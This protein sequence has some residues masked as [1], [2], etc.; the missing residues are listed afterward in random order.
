[1]QTKQIP[2]KLLTDEPCEKHNLQG[3]VIDEN[4]PDEVVGPVLLVQHASK[5]KSTGA[6]KLA[7]DE[8]QHETDLQV[9]IVSK[10]F[11]SS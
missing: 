7:K 1:M 10:I 8:Y 6:F 5:T 2:Q 3:D 11:E 4:G 9:Q